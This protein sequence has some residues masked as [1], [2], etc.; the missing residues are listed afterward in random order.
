VYKLPS[1]GKRDKE[2]IA[3]VA[4]FAPAA[5]TGA[6]RLAL[7]VG[8]AANPARRKLP[9]TEALGGKKGASPVPTVD[10][11]TQTAGDA[12]ANAAPGRKPPTLLKPG[13]KPEFG[14]S[15][16]GDGADAPPPQ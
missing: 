2:D 12:P 6:V 10:V 16:A 1:L 3:E 14:K 8:P 7:L 15:N 4:K 13:E 11:P 9:V 5:T